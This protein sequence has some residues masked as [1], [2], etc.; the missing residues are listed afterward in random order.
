[1]KDSVNKRIKDHLNHELSS[2][3]IYLSSDVI[4]YCGPIVDGIENDFLQVVEDLSCDNPL[5]K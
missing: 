4:A 2:L 3:E 1:M 5:P